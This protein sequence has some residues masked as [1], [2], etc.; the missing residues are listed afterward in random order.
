MAKIFLKDYDVYLLDESTENLDP[1]LV[2]NIRKMIVLSS[3][4]KIVIHL[5]QSI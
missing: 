4:S 3:K 5:T 2:S 1:V